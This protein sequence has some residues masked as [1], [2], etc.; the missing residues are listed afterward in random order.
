MNYGFSPEKDAAVGK[1]GN[2]MQI[3]YSEWISKNDKEDTCKSIEE[4][5]ILVIDLIKKVL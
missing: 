3:I 4:F 2:D 5:H 1:L